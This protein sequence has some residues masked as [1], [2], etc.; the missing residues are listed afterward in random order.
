MHVVKIMTSKLTLIPQ[1]IT[2]PEIPSQTE[3]G[4]QDIPPEI[5]LKIFSAMKGSEAVPARG[6]CR[7][8]QELIDDEILWKY[9]LACDFHRV[10]TDRAKEHYQESFSFHRNLT[11]G[12]CAASVTQ[13]TD[14]L[15][16]FLGDGH[17]C[18]KD[19]KIIAGALHGRIKI[20]DLKSGNC[21]K[22]LIGHAWIVISLVLTKEGNLLSSDL[23]GTIKIWNL[24]TGDCINTFAGSG[25]ALSSNVILHEG[26][27]IAGYSNN[28]IKI[29]DLTTGQCQKTL[30]GSQPNPQS[31][32]LI[33]MQ[34]LVL[35]KEGKLISG[36]SDGSI[37]IWNL[38]NAECETILE[39]NQHSVCSLILSR[40]G[41]LISS[42]EGGA[43]KMWDLGS[44][45]CEMDLKAHYIGAD[46]RL[47]SEGKL[48]SNASVGPI[49]VWDLEKGC[50]ERTLEG[51]HSRL[52]SLCLTKEGKLITGDWG[53]TIKVWDLERGVCEVT[54]RT[55]KKSQFL[56]LTSD[57]KLISGDCSRDLLILDF[58]ASHNTV[59]EELADL[60]E[61]TTK[62]PQL[63]PKRV[64]HR[65]LR[66]PAREREQIY[67]ELDK[68]LKVDDAFDGSAE[69]AFHDQKGLSSTLEQKAQ[70]IRNYLIRKST[71]TEFSTAS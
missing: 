29:W 45:I 36:S 67:D 42:F 24:E 59:F 64:M 12:I 39:K 47:T 31:Q 58:N 25:P 70:A 52:T 19:H 54:I 55:D 16:S 5:M 60:F 61:K 62:D 14:D 32:V 18:I 34:A 4:I 20:W 48:I 30:S 49:K 43:I 17:V 51:N 38:E 69:H 56:S 11:K 1:V 57:G 53:G 7:L 28:S 63:D 71:E 2:T 41:K 40:E 68:I 15:P 35:T 66:M 8:W 37:W 3:V 65:F 6:V 50:C 23:R 46:L 26:S 9:F 27:L 22:T 44:G 21:E 10:E 13:L 33:K